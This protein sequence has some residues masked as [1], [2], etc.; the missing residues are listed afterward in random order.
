MAGRSPTTSGRCTMTTTAR[1]RSR[2]K[3]SGKCRVEE[4]AAT[5]EFLAGDMARNIMG[6]C[7]VIDG[8]W[9]IQ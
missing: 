7:I 1:W 9:T 4:V 5:V 3:L 2:A 8:G 6:Q